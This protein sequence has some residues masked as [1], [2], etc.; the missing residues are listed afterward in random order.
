[1]KM[2]ADSFATLVKKASKLPLATSPMIM[3]DV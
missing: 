2:Q 1:M 3:S